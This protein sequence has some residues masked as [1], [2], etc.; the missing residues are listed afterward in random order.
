MAQ[1][2]LDE[3]ILRRRGLHVPTN[4]Y[5]KRV[6]ESENYYNIVNGYK[7]PFI[8]IPATAGTQEQYKQNAAFSEIHALYKFDSELRMSL[9][10][11]ILVVETNIKSAIAYEFSRKYGHE[12]YL[13]TS[14]FDLQPGNTDRL[15]K[16]VDLIKNLQAD[17]ARQLRHRAICHYMSEYGY[18]PL[19]VLVKILSFGTTSKFYDLMKQP[20]RQSVA[21]RYRVSDSELSK[22]LGL[23][24]LC[25]NKCA[26]D[27][28]LYNFKS[29][30][31]RIQDN[32]IHVQLG[33]PVGP[34]GRVC[35]KDD[36]LATLI[37]LKLLLPRSEFKPL[38]MEINKNLN[39]LSRKLQSVPVTDIMQSMGLPA[40]W[41]SI[42]Q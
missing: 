24:T 9:L 2:S 19:W 22:L 10:R 3:H 26:H 8:A 5:P 35:G 27:E 42:T 1:N 6:L 14:N 38:A 7:D 18:V 25:R 16:I 28:R 23:L 21:R 4:G 33:I 30:K 31:I 40:N 29:T 20:D 13:K 36:I 41:M 37:A 32:P 34:N 12:N 17:I 11:R 15:S 39:T